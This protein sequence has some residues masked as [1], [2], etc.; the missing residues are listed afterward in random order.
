VP[1]SDVLQLRPWQREAFDK[2]VASEQPDFLAVA[3][4]GAGKTTFALACARWALAA[5]RRR[6]IVVAPTSHLKTQWSLAAHRLGL[7]LDHN[8]SPTDGIARDVHGIVTTFQQVSTADT[9]KVLRGLAHD[10]FVILDEIHHAGDERAWGD[11]VRTAFEH[12]HRR[13]C[14]SGTPFRS[15]TASI[16]FVRYEETGVGGEA[17]P[18]FTYGY[19]DALRDGGVV[20]PVYFPRFD[21]LMEWS[22]PDGSVLTANFHDELDRTGQSHRLRAA[23]SLQGDWLPAVLG[24]AHERLMTIRESHP[25]A[26]AL[27]I[28][29][30]QEHA[31]DLAR[32]I[33]F[34]FNVDA[35]I[36]VSDDPDASKKIAAFARSTRPWLVAVRM[37]SEGVDIPRLRVGVYASTVVTELFFR[38]AVGRF[39]RWTRGMPSQK[40][41]LYL[42]DDPRLRAH[43]FQIAEA[44]RHVLTPP[45]ERDDEFSP[46]QLEREAAQE[47]GFE[48]EQLSLFS[49]LSSVATGMTVHAFTEDGL[50]L[51]DDEPD[52]PEPDGSFDPGGGIELPDIPTDAGYVLTEGKSVAERKQELRERNMDI[53]RRL[54]DLTGWSHGRV[55]SELNRLAGITSVGAATNEQLERRARHGEAWLRR[56]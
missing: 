37:V 24:Q 19:A 22:A 32:L 53:A 14:L 56:R 36:V 41:Y 51:F 15:D 13:L 39:V 50:T 40:A 45:T 18:D 28:C 46:E 30:D 31:R 35:E 7:H 34:R 11:G 12:A 25:D 26:G 17:Q 6:V 27:A 5:D 9:A 52:V 29:M 3:T 20:R 44:R 1:M 2:F 38:Q 23:L 10:A 49:V 55:Q 33:R 54:V 4:P 16:P 43:A 48:Y 21:G 47:L 42:P 8:W